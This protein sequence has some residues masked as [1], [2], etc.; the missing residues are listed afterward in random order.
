MTTTATWNVFCGKSDVG[1]S[2]VAAGLSSQHSPTMVFEDVWFRD[3]KWLKAVVL[4]S[5]ASTQAGRRWFRSPFEN[6]SATHGLHV[7][8][9]G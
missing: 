2:T 5:Q 4:T 7:L 6:A 3:W 9:V 8:S 1:R